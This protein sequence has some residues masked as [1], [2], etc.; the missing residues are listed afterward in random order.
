MRRLCPLWCSSVECQGSST[1]PVDR[2]SSPRRAQGLTAYGRIFRY[3]CLDSLSLRYSLSRPSPSGNSTEKSPYRVILTRL[4][5]GSRRP[6]PTSTST[7]SCFW[8]RSPIRLTA[9]SSSFAAK[10]VTPITPTKT[11]R[12][13]SGQGASRTLP[14]FYFLNLCTQEHAPKVIDQSKQCSFLLPRPPLRV[15]SQGD[16]TRFASCYASGLFRARNT[17]LLAQIL[18]L[19][20]I[21]GM[22]DADRTDSKLFALIARHASRNFLSEISLAQLGKGQGFAPPR[23]IPSLVETV[24]VSTPFGFVGVASCSSWMV[25]P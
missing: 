6:L 9:K 2:A 17:N 19:R 10:I 21:P 3:V 12:N 16:L 1:L 22:V 13:L 24:P 23:C 4:E 15:T 20:F 7:T 8:Q 5:R 11:Q 18:I 25:G 14:L